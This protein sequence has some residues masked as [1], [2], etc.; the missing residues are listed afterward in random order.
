MACGD[1][2]TTLANFDALI[3]FKVFKDVAGIMPEEFRS[4]AAAATIRTARP[5]KT[6]V[7]KVCLFNE[8]V[9]N[10]SAR[11]LLDLRE[12]L[13]N[14]FDEDQTEDVLGYIPL[15]KTNQVFTSRKTVDRM[16]DLFE[17]ANPGC[18]GDPDHTLADLCVKSGMLVTVNRQ[19]SLQQRS[20]A[21]AVPR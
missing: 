21:S 6:S 9:F 20:D 10:N 3:P 4:C 14:R 13:A 1:G 15:Q 16:V 7:L 8:T 5:T 18:F 12:K 11:M 2:N 17:R 19:A